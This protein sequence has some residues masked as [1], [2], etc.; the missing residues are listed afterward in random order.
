M[1]YLEGLN[2]LL[3]TSI[4]QLKGYKVFLT[5]F[6]MAN[7]NVLYIKDFRPEL[8]IKQASGRIV[9]NEYNELVY[10][11]PLERSF[12]LKEMGD[13]I[14]EYKDRSGNLRQVKE[15][16]WP[17]FDSP[18]LEPET[19]VSVEYAEHETRVLPPRYC[20]NENFW[21]DYSYFLSEKLGFCVSDGIDKSGNHVG[22]FSLRGGHLTPLDIGDGKVIKIT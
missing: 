13:G 19:V 22:T 17:E 21:L 10:I 9:I 1:V 5:N 18:K 11:D 20:M 7:T 6:I 16:S 2:I 14:Y 3:Q 4:D 8:V 12:V 15:V